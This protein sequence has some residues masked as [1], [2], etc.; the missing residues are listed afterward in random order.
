V[1][2]DRGA[3]CALRWHL[4]HDSVLRL[5]MRWA[6]A[7]NKKVCFD[8]ASLEVGDGFEDTECNAPTGELESARCPGLWT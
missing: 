2:A 1:A 8:G 3:R 5:A 7:G 6:V 4:T